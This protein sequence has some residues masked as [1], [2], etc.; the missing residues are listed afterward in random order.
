M[1]QARLV[2]DHLA[3]A[4]EDLTCAR[5]DYAEADIIKTYTLVRNALGHVRNAEA[6]LSFEVFSARQTNESV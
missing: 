3:R 2:V 6:L 4:I 5:A 1:S